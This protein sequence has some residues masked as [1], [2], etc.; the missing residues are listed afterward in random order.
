MKSIPNTLTVLLIY[1]SS[2][3]IRSL[4]V[5]NKVH[6]HVGPSGGVLDMQDS[7]H[8]HPEEIKPNTKTAQFPYLYYGV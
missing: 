4:Y 8:A 3:E 7:L 5:Q 6:V 2:R 1:V